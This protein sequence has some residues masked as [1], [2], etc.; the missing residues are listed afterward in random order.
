MKIGGVELKGP[1]EQVLVLPRPL[2]EDIIIRCKAVLEM[3]QFT[4]MCPEPKAKPVL[5]KGGF[6]PNDKDPGYLALQAKHSENR[7]AYIALKSMEPSE[8]EWETVNMGD[9]S[10]WLNW[11]TELRAA[12]VSSIEINRIVMCIMQANALDEAKLEEARASF[13]L[14][15][16]EGPVKSCGLPTEPQSTSSGEPVKDS[17]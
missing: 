11:E 16:A 8:I 9:P 13:L 5:M 14:G 2:G 7:F 3:D 4:A 15:I 12:S 6:K 17:E 10:T 1:S